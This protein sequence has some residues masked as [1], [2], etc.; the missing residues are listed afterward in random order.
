VTRTRKASIRVGIVAGVVCAIGIYG[1]ALATATPAQARQIHALK[2]QVARDAK[3]I[4]AR[5]ATIATRNTTISLL[6]GMVRSRDA[7]IT[8]DNATITADTG[9][10]SSLRASQSVTV[11]A[12]QVTTP[13]E[14]WALIQKV[15]PLF[16]PESQATFNCGANYWVSTFAFQ[17][18]GSAFQSYNFGQET[19]SGSTWCP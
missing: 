4:K 13:A 8:A 1:P 3:T 18:D 19:L 14:A 15:V 17:S 7:T 2:A 6:G 10:I 12:S 5:N 9:L 11:D 16:M